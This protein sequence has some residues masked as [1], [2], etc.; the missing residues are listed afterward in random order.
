MH[1]RAYYGTDNNVDGWDINY[2][3]LYGCVA[4]QYNKRSCFHRIVGENTS[5]Q[6]KNINVKS[7]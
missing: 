7:G 2:G 6:E 1:D 5:P 4:V 3:E